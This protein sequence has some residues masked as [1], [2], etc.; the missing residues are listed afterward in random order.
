MKINFGN[1]IEVTLSPKALAALRALAGGRGMPLVVVDGDQPP[2][3][4]GERARYTTTTGRPI[5]RPNAYARKG[6]SSMVY[7]A[8]SRAVTVGRDWLKAAVW[9]GII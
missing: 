8:S 6:R 7:H 5:L 2:E 1:H 4:S 9:T 3:V